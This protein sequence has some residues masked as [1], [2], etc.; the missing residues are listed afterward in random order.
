MTIR[1]TAALVI[2][3]A[4]SSFTASASPPETR[5]A[6]FLGLKSFSSFKSSPG[7]VATETLLTSP[8]F[9]SL[10][11]WDELVVSWDAETRADGYLKV[12]ARGLSPGRSTKYF[13]M[14]IWSA[15]PARHTRESVSNQKDA[16]GNV[17]TDTLSLK[18]HCDRVQVRLALGGNEKPKL[19]FLGLCLL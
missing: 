19:K 16:D 4:L 15:D 9:A 13:T 10:V 1:S 17:S 14:G 2:L 7:E 11:K 12:E 18:H 3:A 6:Q 8:E 5:G